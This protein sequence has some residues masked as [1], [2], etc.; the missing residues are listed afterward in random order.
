MGYQVLNGNESAST[1][2]YSTIANWRGSPNTNCG[3]I[4]DWW[5]QLEPLGP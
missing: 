2:V 1:H 5:M 4:T 3:L